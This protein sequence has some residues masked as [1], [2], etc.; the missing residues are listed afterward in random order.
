[1]R[2]RDMVTGEVYY[3][4][5]SRYIPIYKQYYDFLRRRVLYTPERL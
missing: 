1:V 4:E 2:Y 3:W 5:I